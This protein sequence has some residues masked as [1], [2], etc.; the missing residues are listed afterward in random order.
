[1]STRANEF[2]FS[3]LLSLSTNIFELKK[4]FAGILFTFLF[5]EKPDRG[6]MEPLKLKGERIAI[7]YPFRCVEQAMFM[8][9]K[10]KA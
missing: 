6:N 8:C 10:D 1:M 9:F 3:F 5:S 7:D 2:F 4:R